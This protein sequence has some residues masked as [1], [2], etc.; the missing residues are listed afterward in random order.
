[1]RIQM[2]DENFGRVRHRYR[3]STNA[4]IEINVNGLGVWVVA[5]AEGYKALARCCLLMAHPELKGDSTP[6]SFASQLADSEMSAEGRLLQSFWGIGAEADYFQD[7]VLVR[8][9]VIGP[10]YWDERERTGNSPL[11]QAFVIRELHGLNWLETAS[12][13]EVVDAFGTPRRVVGDEETYWYS[14]E[15]VLEVEYRPDGGVHIYGLALASDA[16]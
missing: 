10:E 4:K 2:S 15:L 8:S 5:N 16:T 7:L 14:E 13:A 9:D 1:M 6:Y 12:R 11:T 3:P